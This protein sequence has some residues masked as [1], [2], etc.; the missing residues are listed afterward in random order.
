MQIVFE[1]YTSDGP[2]YSGPV[3]LELV[4]HRLTQTLKGRAPAHRLLPY[5]VGE[6][7]K[8]EDADA[9]NSEMI[10]RCLGVEEKEYLIE[11]KYIEH[12]RVKLL[13]LADGGRAIVILFGEP[14]FV[15][16]A[17]DGQEYKFFDLDEM[18]AYT[19]G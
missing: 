13:T 19:V 10:W 3:V 12:E 7:V 18:R 15:G 16:I 2:G 14:Q 5:A 1:S 8:V 9:S 4:G 17:I 6:I 11:P